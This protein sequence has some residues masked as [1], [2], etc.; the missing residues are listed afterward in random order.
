MTRP[1][2]KRLNQARKAKNIGGPMK[3]GSVSTMNRPIIL[4]RLCCKLQSGIGAGST[5]FLMNLDG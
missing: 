1:G 4:P 5:M 3:Y 2:M